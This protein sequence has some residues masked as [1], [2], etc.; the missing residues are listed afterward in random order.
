[1]YDIK[2]YKKAD[3][4]EE[5]IQLLREDPDARLISGGTDVLVK[6]HQGK[7]RFDRLVDIHDLPELKGVTLKENGDVVIGPGTTFTE[8]AESPAVRER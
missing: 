1:M 7:G 8:T 4:I 5:A 3:S 2:S 6:L